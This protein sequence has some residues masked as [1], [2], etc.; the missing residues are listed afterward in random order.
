MIRN[1]PPASSASTPAAIPAATPAPPAPSPA[2]APAT[3]FVPAPPF[4]VPP[5][6]PEA[7]A[8]GLAAV[9]LL[10]LTSSPTGRT[11]PAARKPQSNSRAV[12]L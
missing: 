3:G 6:S 7:S 8:E 9:A 1:A 2:A 11:L 12:S 10:G 4:P 5:A